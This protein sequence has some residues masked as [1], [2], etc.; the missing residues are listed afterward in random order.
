MNPDPT[1]YTPPQ[2]DEESITEK[3]HTDVVVIGAGLA[4]LTAALSAAQSGVNVIQLE[5]GPSYN[6]RGI[7]NAAINSRLQ[8]AS[9]IKI[10]KE[11][12]IYTIM[13]TAAYRGDQRVVNT[14]ADHCDQVMEWL[15]D[16]AEAADMEVALDTTHRPWYFPNYQLIHVWDV[17]KYGFQ[18]SLAKM[19][20][21]NGQ[22]HGVDV[23]FKTPAVRLLRRDNQRVT[24]VIA[25]NPQGDLI[26]V[27]ADKAVVLCSGDYGNDLEMVKQYCWKGVDKLPNLYHVMTDLSYAKQNIM[28]PYDNKPNTGDGHKMG[29]W[30]DAAI[31]DP[32]HCAMLFDYTTWSKGKLFDLA[33]QPWLYVN[34][35]GER[36]MNEDLPWGYECA[37]LMQQPETIAWSIWDTKWEEEVVQLNCQCCKNM[38]P[39]TYLWNPAWLDEGIADGNVLTARTIEDLGRKMK[40]PA[41]VFAAT[42]KRYNEMAK[43]GK[44]IDFGKHPERLTV[45]EKPLFYA[46]QV[47]AVYLVI[48][49]GLKI[50]PQLQ[51]LDNQGDVIPGLYAAGNVSGSFF[52]SHYPTTLPGLSHS[53]AW[54]FG[55]TGRF[56]RGGRIGRK[57]SL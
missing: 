43:N 57:V 29:M 47:T 52:G 1:V 34:I 42:V 41:D 17:K 25:K 10:D 19:L 53:R 6:F 33:R 32:P 40:V 20:Y 3:I 11:Q 51:V 22:A 14:W 18:A 30:I 48:L 13:E 23:R 26:Q 8:K 28:E 5:K 36:F 31:D 50:N 37:Q 38:G 15:L 39:P 16:M 9:G 46:A 4:G 49:G 56:K 2:I 55:A 7:H 35:K 21:E 27:N 44:D 24:G 54:T 45:L 12:L